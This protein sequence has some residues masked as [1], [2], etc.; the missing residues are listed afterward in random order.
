MPKINKF[1][2]KLS[3][4]TRVNTSRKHSV[5]Q[6]DPSNEAKLSK[7]NQVLAKSLIHHGL[8]NK[9]DGPKSI[10]EV[11]EKARQDLER[12]K[13]SPEFIKA[14]NA[15]QKELVK[16]TQQI[17]L[18][19]MLLKLI[20][21]AAMETKST[22]EALKLVESSP[23]LKHQPE[24]LLELKRISKALDNRNDLKNMD[25]DYQLGLLQPS[26]AEHSSN[27]V[28]MNRIRK[29]T[30]KLSSAS[31]RIDKENTGLKYTIIADENKNLIA[32]K[33]SINYDDESEKK[34]LRRFLG[35]KVND[36][37]DHENQKVLSYDRPHTH[38]EKEGCIKVIFGRGGFGK[39]R[40]AEDMLT[41]Q[42]MAVKKLSSIQEA[43]KEKTEKEKLISVLK[44]NGNPE[45][46]KCF[47]T[48]DSIAVSHGKDGVAKAYITSKLQDG[49]GLTSLEKL[50]SKK[51]SVGQEDFEKTHGDFILKTMGSLEVLNR[52]GIVHGDLNWENFI[53]GKI[54]DLSGLC[55]KRGDYIGMAKLKYL[56]PELEL[57]SKG[58]KHPSEESYKAHVSFS[59]GRMLLESIDLNADKKF[60]L[61]NSSFTGHPAQGYT[62]DTPVP[63]LNSSGEPFSDYEKSVIKLAYS[64]ADTKPENRPT[65]EEAKQ[66]MRE[67]FSNNFS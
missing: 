62:E 15:L 25:V 5:E 4:F 56:P 9:A 24:A 61:M 34:G 40:L 46:I 11:F 66:K 29:K 27:V 20:K 54:S 51:S 37:F 18:D 58:F 67:I 41:G 19:S 14:L 50:Y 3:V 31:N 59:F 52:N 39:V 13:E 55:Y 42:E 48:V 2:P 26:K 16:E 35:K 64:L 1:L 63:E 10:N 38:P 17:H 23:G 8:Y 44:S 7:M 47:L 53:G 30:I 43:R 57:K 60:P 49:D 28:D 21:K 36:N 32:L 6:T 65:I 33:N 12:K 22:S 45:D